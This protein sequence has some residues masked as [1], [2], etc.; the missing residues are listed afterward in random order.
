M[1]TL[2]FI[3]GIVVFAVGLLVSIAW[4][5]LGHLSTAKL[6][7]IRVPQYMVGFGPTI[8]SRTKGDT[9]Y[10]IKA[11]PLG[12]YIRMIGMFPPD[13]AGR[14]SARSTSPWRGMIEDARSAAFEE[15][16]E[17][18][19]T[20]MFYTRK[21]WKRVIVMFAGPFMNLILAVGLFLTVLM[22]FGIQQQTTT[23]SSVSP[24]VIAQSQNRDTCKKSDPASPAQAAGLKAGDRIVSFDGKSTKNWDK[25]SDLIRD[26]A[27]RNVAIVVER[28]GQEQTLHAKIAT[29][30]VAEK[31]SSGTY[32]P[33]KYVKAGFLGFSSAT[34]VER[35]SFGES[36]TWMDDRVGD[37]VDSLLSLPGKIPALWDA[38]FGDGPREPD[39]PMGIVGAARVT[40]EIATLNIP[41]SQQLAMFVFVLAGFNLSLFLFNMLPLLPLDGGHIAGALWE[42]LRRNLARVLRRPDPGPFDV[43][44]LMPVAYVVAGI[45][46]CFTLLVLVADVVNPVKIS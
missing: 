7:G 25:L 38:A 41:A 5:E 4:H 14:V 2:M 43:A 16:K 12:G 45:F 40:G 1:T 9:E 34:G 37:A 26:S 30:Q 36:V 21:P 27:G 32:V 35:Q 29:N 10:G 18:D 28:G 42:S 31:D 22:G 6:F 19:E 3:L 17:G 46:V 44:K 24:C 20:R 39:S 11:V 33:G 13:D 15:L 8:W 23:V